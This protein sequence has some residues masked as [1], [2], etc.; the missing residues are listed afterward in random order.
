MKPKKITRVALVTAIR[1]WEY[2]VDND[3]KTETDPPSLA[4]IDGCRKRY[5]GFG[6][7]AEGAPQGDEPYIVEG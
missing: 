3:K 2:A 4:V 1:K 6:W 7:I 5:V